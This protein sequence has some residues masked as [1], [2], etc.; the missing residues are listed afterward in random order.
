MYSLWLR[1]YDCAI[2][3]S[4]SILY[5]LVTRANV[6]IPNETGNF[7]EKKKEKKYMKQNDMNLAVY[8]L[9]FASN[10]LYQIMKFIYFFFRKFNKVGVM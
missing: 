2:S 4:I 10:K 3:W 6:Y 5:E 8:L 9:N 1:T 7:F